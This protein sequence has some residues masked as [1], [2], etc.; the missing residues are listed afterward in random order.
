MIRF[1]ELA[2]PSYTERVDKNKFNSLTKRQSTLNK[3]PLSNWGENKGSIYLYN[4]R[5]GV[6]K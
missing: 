4:T 2:L 6:T 1:S 5:N 3:A